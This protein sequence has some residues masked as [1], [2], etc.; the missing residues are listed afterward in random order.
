MEKLI[1][2][3]QLSGYIQ[4][5]GDQERIWGDEMAKIFEKLSSESFKI[6]KLTGKS[7]VWPE[8]AKLFGGKYELK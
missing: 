1:N 4:I 8:F 3:S 5:K 2:L 7:D 6:V